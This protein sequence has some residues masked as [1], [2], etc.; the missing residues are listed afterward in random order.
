MKWLENA[1][2]EG[3]AESKAKEV[4]LPCETG[5]EFNKRKGISTPIERAFGVE[6]RDQL[7][8]ETA[9]MFYTRGLSFNLARNPHYLR[10]FQFNVANKI[11]SKIF[12]EFT[13]YINMYLFWNLFNIFFLLSFLCRF[14]CFAVPRSSAT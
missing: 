3:K 7:D 11:D 12:L 14:L 9:R 6:I 4:G 1:Y 10:A 13:L 2:E 5:V 8:Q